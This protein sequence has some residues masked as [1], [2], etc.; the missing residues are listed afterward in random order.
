MYKDDQN[1]NL[2]GKNYTEFD[3]NSTKIQPREKLPEMT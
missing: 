2:T 3:Q 1:A